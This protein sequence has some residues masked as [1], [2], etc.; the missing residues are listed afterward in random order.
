[1]HHIPLEDDPCDIIGKAMRGLEALLDGKNHPTALEKIASPLKLSSGA[2]VELPSYMPNIT[3][4]AGMKMIVSPFGHAGVNSY[5][6]YNSQEALVFDTG[7]DSTLIL[8]F[9]T[10]KNLNVAALII[11]H[12]HHDHIS[13][14]Q[15]FDKAPIILPGDTQHGQQYEFGGIAFTALD[16]SG[17]ATPA[18][19]YFIEYLDSPI[20]I[21]GDAI[22]AGSMGGTLG[23][24]NYQLAFKT[25]RENILT[26]PLDTVIGTGHKE[27]F[28]HHVKV[29]LQPIQMLHH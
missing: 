18:R 16:V 2:L 14:I 28:Y 4:P 3:P 29:D 10:A 5:I 20:C 11:T 1:M 21:L 8:N 25:I 12:E 22:F 27:Y 24:Q 26:L 6:I 7:T 15:D 13:G 9:L 17:H 19:A 23:P